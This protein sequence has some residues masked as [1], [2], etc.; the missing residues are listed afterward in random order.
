MNMC[1]LG[2][3]NYKRVFLVHDIRIFSYIRL[4]LFHDG[5]DDDDDD[6]DDGD[7]DDDDDV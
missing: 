2:A 5:D 4:L 3:I 7:D 6:D 1:L